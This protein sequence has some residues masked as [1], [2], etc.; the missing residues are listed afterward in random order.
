[1]KKLVLII[2]LIIATLISFILI[3]NSGLLAGLG[4]GKKAIPKSIVVNYE[5]PRVV[6]N[7]DA[8]K[9]KAFGKAT[10]AEFL[11]HLTH[12]KG[13]IEI[14]ATDI[15]KA[16]TLPNRLYDIKDVVSGKI[17]DQIQTDENGYGHSKELDLY[18]AY[19]VIS[20]DKDSNY[21]AYGEGIILDMNADLIT[22]FFEY[23]MPEYVT[24]YE[25]NEYGEVIINSVS[26]TGP[27][28]MQ[29]P[30]LPNGC[31]ITSAASL[32][33]SYGMEA[34]HLMLADNYLPTSGFYSVGDRYYG[35]DPNVAFSGHP[36]DYNGW[37]VFAPP[38]VLAINNYIADIDE[39]YLAIDIT[40]STREEIKNYLSSGYPVVAW[41]TLNLTLSQKAYG[42][43]ID[44]TDEFY[45]PYINLHC[46]VIYGYEPGYLIVMD[47]L[48]GLM[49]YNEN[50]FF[51]A[52]ESIG[53][54][55]I[56]LEHVTNK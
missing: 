49:R 30:E 40:G 33:Q 15:T 41:T 26:L 14:Y 23:E 17:V 38:V 16:Y 1:M 48:Q 53:S 10:L 7:L 22:L 35:P 54:R 46:T 18:V 13:I 55:G 19:K 5:D 50:S 45:R 37:Y 25:Q 8:S 28:I 12:K 20:V 11:D 31:E 36:R 44:G 29:N 51:N 34:D 21:K 27:V 6:V 4:L 52:Y 9:Y 39:D 43:Y 47:P 32:L 56:I 3:T 24:D 2:G 42:W